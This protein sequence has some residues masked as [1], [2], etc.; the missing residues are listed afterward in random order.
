MIPEETRLGQ[1]MRTLGNFL[2]NNVRR[3]AEGRSSEL[4]TGF[5]RRSH[6]DVPTGLGGA[7][8]DAGSGSPF[9]DL[10]DGIGRMTRR[11]RTPT[12]PMQVVDGGV[13]V[14]GSKARRT[15]DEILWGSGGRDRQLFHAPKLGSRGDVAPQAPAADVRSEIHGI[16][17]SNPAD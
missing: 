6:V 1:G 5:G 8:D 2:T 16:L 13:P 11:E 3:G 10:V 9:Q 4:F 12:E 17:D 15:R 7:V 14:P